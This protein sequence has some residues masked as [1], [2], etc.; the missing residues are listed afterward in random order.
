[1]AEEWSLFALPK[2]GVELAISAEPDAGLI[3]VSGTRSLPESPFIFERQR[4]PG[5]QWFASDDLDALA[6]SLAE[7]EGSGVAKASSWTLHSFAPNPDTE[8]SRTREAQALERRVLAQ[9][10]QRH[11]D[12]LARFRAAD[13]GPVASDTVVW[14]LCRVSGG[15]WS[16]IATRAE[17]SDPYPGGVH[18]MPQDALAPSR[19][20]LKVEEALD[21]MRQSGLGGSP[22]PNET[23]VDLGAAPGGWT[24]A[25]LKRGCR[26]HAVD[27]GPLKLQSHGDMGG[28]V[29]HLKE[30]GLRFRPQ[31]PVD[32]LLSDMLIAPG[33]ALGLLRKW[34]D[35]GWARQLVVNIKLPQAEP[36]VALTPILDYLRGVP[37]LRF[38]L[39]QLYHD[40]RE[41]TLMGALSGVTRR[42]E[43]PQRAPQKHKPR[44][45]PGGRAG[46]PPR[47]GPRQGRQR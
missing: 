17:L 5:A 3:S 32:W 22:R 16:S 18:R 20:Y 43:V 23:V 38:H 14:Q 7:R 45:K 36:L 42:T 24:W 31:R 29:L 6:A 21:V 19:S 34:L 47:R 46:K 4:L 1:L 27:N 40:R 15:A 26:V 28:E 35:G 8:D 37:G 44:E 39:R 13:Q 33:Q 41:V 30:D 2:P 25:F 11:A 12:A 9:V 10:E